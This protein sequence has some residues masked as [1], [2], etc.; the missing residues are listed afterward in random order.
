MS[1]G[2]VAAGTERHNDPFGSLHCRGEG[3]GQLSEQG[4]SQSFYFLSLR[5][6]MAF[7]SIDRS[8]AACVSE[9]NWAATHN[10]DREK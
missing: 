6:T 9:L 2:S 7:V 1:A 5:D 10:V 8:S 4:W 3:D